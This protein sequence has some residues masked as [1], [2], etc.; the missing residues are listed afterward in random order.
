MNILEEELEKERW[1]HAACLTIA[2]GSLGW[3]GETW[4]ESEAIRAV[5]RLRKEYEMQRVMIK[6]MHVIQGD[7]NG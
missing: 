2:E 6:T 7:C 1:Q 4:A 5:R 3:D